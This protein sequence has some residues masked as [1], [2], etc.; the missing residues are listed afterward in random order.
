[1]L[2]SPLRTLMG[3]SGTSLS[4]APDEIS[5][6][7]V[8]WFDADDSAT[9]TLNGGDVSGW[10][11]KDT[12]TQANDLAQ[13]VAANQP[14]LAVADQNGLDGVFFGSGLD[15][16]VAAVVGDTEM[17]NIFAGGGFL[18]F[19]AKWDDQGATTISVL[20]K[21][22]TSNLGWDFLGVNA[23]IDNKKNFR[24]S[25]KFSGNGISAEWNSDTR[26]I[27]TDVAS[28]IT[29]EYDE[30]DINNDPVITIDGVVQAITEAIAPS[31]TP[32]S[33]AGTAFIIGS[34][35]STTF[36]G[37]MYE[38]ALYSTIPSAD[39]Q[40]ALIQHLRNKWGV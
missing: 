26:N 5:A 1:M 29:I 20:R 4:L 22:T 7:L 38:L 6:T 13:A 34:A 33:D 8:G 19:A 11:D 2:G 24:F 16:N 3:Q 25:R 10:D 17:N 35:A 23:V 27:P 15:D 37:T 39:D 21:P 30:G 28:I 32:D 31:G 12:S 14:L 40:V 36:G 9:I 18:A